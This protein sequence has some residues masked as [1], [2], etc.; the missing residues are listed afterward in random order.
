MDQKTVLEDVVLDPIKTYVNCFGAL[1]FYGLVREALG[2][3]IVNLH[4]RRSLRVTHFGKSVVNGHRFLFVEISGSGFVFCHRAHHIAHNFG[5]G[6]KWAIGG[7][8]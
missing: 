3:G 2:G 7:R 6:E 4:R 1:L 8:G 5:Q